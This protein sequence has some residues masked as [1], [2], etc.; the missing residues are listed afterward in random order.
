MNDTWHFKN[1]SAK[2]G[3]NKRLCKGPRIICDIAVFDEADEARA[4]F[5]VKACNFHE[6]LVEALTEAVRQAKAAIE[7]GAGQDGVGYWEDLLEAIEPTLKA[8]Q[9]TQ[10]TLVKS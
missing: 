10:L 3:I 9:A 5:I 6:P 1:L 4:K 8:A 2:P 7:L